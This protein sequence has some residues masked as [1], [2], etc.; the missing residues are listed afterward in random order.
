MSLRYWVLV[1][2]LGVVWG[3]TFF[4]NEVV[5]R[6]LGPLSTSAS[7]LVLG[8]IGCWVWLAVI[9]RSA[10]V[11]HRQF[12]LLVAFGTF[13]YT[14]P[15]TI[16]PL[17]QQFITSSA[18]GIA[19]AMTPILVVVVSHLWPE[20]EKATW[21]KTAGVALGFV[22]IVIVTLPTLG[23][24]GAS[25]PV[26]LVAA[27]TSP[28]C[29]AIAVNLVRSL[30]G[31]GRTEMTAWSLLIGSVVMVPLSL[32]LEGAPVVT[33][34]ET[35]AS[36]AFA[37]FVLTAG[38]FILFFWLVPRIGGTNASTIAFIAPVSA[39]WLGVVVLGEEITLVQWVG[40]GVIAVGLMCVDGRLVRRIAN[41]KPQG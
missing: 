14:L 39:L 24:Q 41:T 40:I 20:G 2:A 13:Q 33:R 9:G 32:G 34:P 5:L 22:G 38:A 28:L 27:L 1:L 12:W 29:Y 21:Y 17:T 31:M 4:F 15:L 19:N 16:Y 7:R 10:A 23:G 37:G 26:Y 6:E 35:W 8:A 36:M 18:A 11:A 3:S 30:D 25:D